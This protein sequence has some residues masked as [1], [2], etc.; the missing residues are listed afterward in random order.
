MLGRRRAPGG[1][2]AELTDREREVLAQL[3]EGKSNLASPRRC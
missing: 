3:A 2:L 1:P